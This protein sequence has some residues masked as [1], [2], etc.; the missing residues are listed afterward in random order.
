MLVIFELL[1]ISGLIGACMLTSDSSKI[2]ADGFDCWELWHVHLHW[3][4]FIIRLCGVCRAKVSSDGPVC[5]LVD[6]P[7]DF[8]SFY[9]QNKI[10]KMLERELTKLT[11]LAWYFLYLETT[12]LRPL[13]HKWIKYL[14]NSSQHEPGSRSESPLV[15]VLVDREKRLLS[16]IIRSVSRFLVS[17][18]WVAMT[19]RHRFIMKNEPIYSNRHQK[20]RIES[21]FIKNSPISLP[22]LNTQSR[23]SCRM[24]EHLG[25]NTWWL[26]SSPSL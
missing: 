2:L 1:F 19:T 6:F 21:I 13:W 14:M 23:S 15:R 7:A 24:N 17:E 5:M 3:D 10:N 4:C 18:N 20:F 11:I 12:R 22:Q 16:A 9:S 26:P 8:L 25:Y